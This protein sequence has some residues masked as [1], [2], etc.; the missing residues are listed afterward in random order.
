M[1]KFEQS[2]SVDQPATAGAVVRPADMTRKRVLSWA[3]VVATLALAACGGGSSGDGFTP[4]PPAP[5]VCTATDGGGVGFSLG[6]CIDASGET[7][8]VFQPADA[9]VVIVEEPSGYVLS[10]TAPA[11]LPEVSLAKAQKTEVGT[12]DIIGRLRGDA[13]EL[14]A[15]SDNQTLTP[16]Y[17]A[18]IDFRNARDYEAKEGDAPLVPLKLGGFGIWERF[19]KASFADGYF[20]GW[21]A[22]R[23]DAT[24]RDEWPL[25]ERSYT[26]L[27]VGVLSP[28]GAGG[29][30]PSS[31]GFS[32]RVTLRADSTG[33]LEGRIA[34]F[35]VS[36]GSEPKLIVEQLAQKDLVFDGANNL[37]GQPVNA[38][39]RIDAGPDDKGK[40]EARFLGVAGNPGREIVG[41]FVFETSDGMVGTGAF[42]AVAV[43]P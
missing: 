41:R 14:D 7:R 29:S 11:T 6:V 8:T 37:P 1:R 9:N 26:G 2:G 36:Q 40:V 32:A 17:V 30:R 35:Y 21:A 42:G 34:E 3:P 25:A 12:R 38:T 33:L 4:T 28:K 27:V 13:Y 16:P 15:D 24:A 20:G 31:Q 5:V 18:L 10:L 39:L 22:P 23:A 19:G 43:Q